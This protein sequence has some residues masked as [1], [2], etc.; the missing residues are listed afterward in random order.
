M[1]ILMKEE[2]E[3]H[4]KK[5]LDPTAAKGPSE[6]FKDISQLFY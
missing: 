6:N 5:I 1:K 3:K 4:N 2:K